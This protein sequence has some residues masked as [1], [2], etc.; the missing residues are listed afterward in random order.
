MAARSVVAARAYAENHRGTAII[1]DV[2]AGASYRTRGDVGL[3]A[4][5]NDHL[6]AY[7]GH[8]LLY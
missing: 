3:P 8:E 4:L 1:I 7:V 5:A 6:L 2:A